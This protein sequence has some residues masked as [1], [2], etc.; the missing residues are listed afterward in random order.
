MDKNEAGDKFSKERQRMVNRHLLG[1]D[2]TDS[3]VMEA[4]REIPREEFISKAYQSQAYADG[5]LPIG[6]GQ[7]ISQPYIVA[8]MTQELRIDKK[9]DVLEIG[10][11]SGYQAAVL[12]RLAKKV[13][14][15]ERFNELA[16]SAMSILSRLGVE[17]VEFYIGDGSC[18]WPEKRT[19]ERII[20]TAA[21]PQIP[22]PLIDQLAAGGII[23]APVGGESVQRLIVCKKKTVGMAEKYICDVR[24]V[25][26][27]GRYGFAE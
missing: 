18:G 6:M 12:C 2:I 27:V 8:L 16:E 9:C 25:K 10:T 24:F 15:I 26:L 7:T 1:R 23:V 4:M 19:F 5:P 13:Y 11:G 22:Q 14:T 3:A 17:N 21:V 20:I